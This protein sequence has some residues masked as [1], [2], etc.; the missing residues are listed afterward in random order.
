MIDVSY[1]KLLELVDLSKT[2]RLNPR[3]EQEAIQTVKGLMLTGPDGVASVVEGMVSLPWS[4]GVNAIM[5][6]WLTLN[7]GIKKQLLSGMTTEAYL[8]DNGKRF[9]LSLGRAFLRS[10]APLGCKIIVAVAHEIAAGADPLPQQKHLQ[11]FFHIMVGKGRP[12]VTNL[13]VES[14]EQSDL[15]AL[16]F[17]SVAATFTR[18]SFL[19]PSPPFTQLQ[20]LKWAAP[21]GRLEALPQPILDLILEAVRNWNG[22]W[23]TSLKRECTPLPEVIA[24][25]IPENVDVV[26]PTE[27]GEVALD[28]EVHPNGNGPRRG[29]FDRFERREREPREAREPREPRDSRDPRESRNPRDNRF[30]RGR[31]FDRPPVVEMAPDFSF[32][33]SVEQ[34]QQYVG[35]IEGELESLRSS[36]QQKEAALQQALA[37]SAAG[38]SDEMDSKPK[39]GRKTK[40]ADPADLESLQ[41]HNE[42]LQ[43]TVTELQRRIEEMRGE[44]EDIATSRDA[45][46]RDGAAV[47]PADEFRNLVSIK[48]AP[49][50]EEYQALEKEPMT[51]ALGEHCRNRWGDLFEALRKL[52]IEFA[53]KPA[54]KKRVT[55]A[56][57]TA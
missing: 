42:Q 18:A 1:E 38:N 55:R 30:Q 45:H 4:V 24:A 29:R 7:D 41:Q 19:P 36:L 21:T 48:L 35:K 9:R 26:A 57:A 40:K 3:Q 22:R 6:S 51:T 43:E 54:P 13:N 44:H 17:C 2:G 33:K 27:E 32:P 23:Q 50:V 37:Q 10:D 31:D 20:L 49:E 5:D 53:A 16:L 12:W 8:S 14:L 15:D 11:T 28:G 47:E 34:I 39:K 46:S 25:V 56:K 52:G